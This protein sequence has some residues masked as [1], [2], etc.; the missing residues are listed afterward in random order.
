MAIVMDDNYRLSLFILCD[1]SF[2]G[3]DRSIEHSVKAEFKNFLVANW[4]DCYTICSSRCAS[5]Y[6]HIDIPYAVHH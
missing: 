6:R 4:D 5:A 3:Y 1:K 2:S